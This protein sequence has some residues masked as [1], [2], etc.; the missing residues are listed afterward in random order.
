M[1]SHIS[2]NSR[3]FSKARSNGVQRTGDIKKLAREVPVPAATKLARIVVF[4]AGQTVEAE[5]EIRQ[6]YE[7]R[8]RKHA[9]EGNSRLREHVGV[10]LLC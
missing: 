5:D 1:I 9:E 2:R 3:T 7:H 8:E 4:E 6:L 10:P